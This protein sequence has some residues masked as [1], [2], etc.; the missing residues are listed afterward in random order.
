MKK[1]F[2]KVLLWFFPLPAFC[3]GWA[4]QQSFLCWFDLRFPVQLIG[5]T[6]KFSNKISIKKTNLF[7]S[8]K[9]NLWKVLLWF[10]FYCGFSAHL[11]AD[12]KPFE[13]N[14]ALSKN[15]QPSGLS[16]GKK[17]YLE[18]NLDQKSHHLEESESFLARAEGEEPLEESFYDLP[19]FHKMEGIEIF[20][21]PVFKSQAFSESFSKRTAINAIVSA[22]I[23]GKLKWQAVETF[24]YQIQGLLVGR[25]GFTQSLYDRDD[26]PS[27]L[28][29]LDGF[30]EWRPFSDLSMKF[31]VIQQ[32][33]LSA[34]LLIADKTFASLVGGLSLDNPFFQDLSFL[35]QAAIPENVSGLTQ[36][37][38]QIVAGVPLFLSFSSKL[39]LP[40]F[41]DMDLRE[42]F[43]LFC[44]YNLPPAVANKSRLY[45]NSVSGYGSDT[46]FLHS[47][48][49]WHNDMQF[50]R[51]LSDLWFVKGGWEYI[52][53]FGAPNKYNEG[54]RLYSA[55]YYNYK[56]F[57]EI[58]GIGEWFAN[59]SDSSVAYYNSEIYGH[60]NRRGFLARLQGHLFSS[61]LTLGGFLAYSQPIDDQRIKSPTGSS[62]SFAVFLKTNYIA[63]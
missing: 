56:N 43:S 39:A 52:Y 12:I 3:R 16:A 38:S 62:F 6:H 58:Q 25:S 33:F 7:Q 26:R 34:P 51:R 13:K 9:A 35:F 46:S 8:V 60:N 41:F 15:S 61:G 49:G 30:F 27:G 5:K 44:Y 10:F 45:G 48:Y 57:M 20:W 37:S 40:A 24:S 28:H 29:L 63:I 14:K 19:D 11:S 50:H 47:F 2:K 22:E 17:F 1:E 18:K 31:G 42:A 21:K 54:F 23:Y 36:R 32:S 59:Q 55:L 4:Y 53:N